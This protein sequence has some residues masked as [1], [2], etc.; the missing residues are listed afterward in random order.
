MPGRFGRIGLLNL[1]SQG[2]TNKQDHLNE[3]LN[4]Q[5]P[6]VDIACITEHWFTQDIIEFLNIEDFAVGSYFARDSHIR[7]GVVTLVRKQLP[8][9]RIDLS[10]FCIEFHIE[11]CA[12]HLKRKNLIVLTVYRSPSPVGDVQVF[13]DVLDDVLD[14]IRA[15]YDCRVVMAGDYNID[16]L[17][18][19]RYPQHRRMLKDF[20]ASHGFAILVKEPT[21]VT[22]ESE[23]CLDNILLDMQSQSSNLKIVNPHLSDHLG[24]LVEV[25]VDGHCNQKQEVDYYATRNINSTNTRLFKAKL[26][27]VD[28]DPLLTS[29]CVNTSYSRFHQVLMDIYDDVFPLTLKKRKPKEPTGVRLSEK[30]RETKNRLDALW[31]ISRVRR[32][33]DSFEAYQR[34]KGY[35]KRVIAEDQQLLNSKYIETARNPQRAMWHI[36]NKN[37]NQLKKTKNESSLTADELN[38]YFV[39]VGASV[40]G[41][42]TPCKERRPSSYQSM[43]MQGTTADEIIRITAALKPKTSN[44]CYGMNVALIKEIVETIA[45]PLAQLF[46]QSVTTGVFPDLLK[47]AVVTCIHK[48]GDKNIPSNYRPISILPAVSK[49]F[50]TLIKNRIMDYITHRQILTE[51]QHGFRRGKTTVTAMTS[52]LNEISEAFDSGEFAQ[53]AFCDLSKAFDTISH[54]ILLDKLNHYGIRG[55]PHALLTSYLSDRSQRVVWK[56]MESSWKEITAG[57]P[58]GSILGPVLFLLYLNDLPGKVT[59]DAKYLF[60][61]DTTFLNKHVDKVEVQKKTETTLKE[62]EQWFLAN[63]MNLNLAKTKTL[64]FTTRGK[65]EPQSTKFLGVIFQENLLWAQHIETVC[66]KLSQQLFLLRR[67]MTITTYSTARMAYFGN[68]HSVAVYG[69]LVWGSSPAMHDV[70]LKQKKA[71]RILSSRKSRDSCRGVFPEIKI[72]TVPSEFILSCLCYVHESRHTFKTGATTHQHNTRGQEKL[73]IPFHRISRSQQSTNYL[74]VK[75]YNKLPDKY[76]VAD[77]AGFRKKAKQ[78]LMRGAYYSVQEFLQSEL[79]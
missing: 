66:A 57:V 48:K 19:S 76:K 54:N 50:E 73:T 29:N 74:G 30:A 22:N 42:G 68:F 10:A 6:H 67:L 46:N 27:L 58:Q 4:V 41:Q 3:V 9:E 71:V 47:T 60:A 55:S 77:V 56:G 8:F 33:R 38:G 52:M 63:K 21:R 65:E 72:L 13:F 32:N 61:D 18:T 16:Y 79:V 35:Y 26:S 28:W 5:Y 64:T 12:V 23:S 20:A 49:I 44:D 45:E 14:F 15:R 24:V 59:S 75:L 53:V 31:V 17:E 25:E 78:L 51:H 70:F 1:N 40:G 43:Y 37:R 39:G 69:I 62:A 36:I 2:L 34:Y 7:G 11:V